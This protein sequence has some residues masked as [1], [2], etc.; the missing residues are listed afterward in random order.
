MKI[1]K[2]D[3]K[4]TEIP[5]VFESSKSLSVAYLKLVFK[6]S[7]V[8]RENK[9]GLAKLSAMLLNEGDM[10]L[11]SHT[12]AK[13]LEKR[14]ISLHANAGFE[15]FNF[16]INCLKEHF[17][18]GLSMLKKLLKSPNLTSETLAKCKS[19]TLGE[20][21]NNQN[22]N[23]YLAQVGLNEILYAN[24]NLGYAS[25]GDKKSIDDISLD[26]VRDF[27]KF[28]DLSNLFI[29][30]GGDVNESELQNI[31]DVLNELEVGKKAEQITLKTSNNCELKEIIKKSEQAYVYFGA[32]YHVSE[33]ERYMASVAMYILG[34]G[35]F[36][37][38]LM[39]EVRVKRGLAYS[40]YAR[41]LYNLSHSHVYG[42]LQTKNESKDEAISVVKAEFDKFYKHGVSK[43]ELDLAKKFLQGSLALRLETLFR[44]LNIAESEFYRGKELGSFLHEL[45]KIKA[46]KLDKLNEFIYKH[47]EI[48]QLSF[49]VLRDEI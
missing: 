12:F 7:G 11:G 18:F 42:Y 34:E 26:D 45:N 16:E 39:E 29:V 5:V 20:I 17:D 33:D 9:K 1:K 10:S 21:A 3:V 44:R 32:P 30:Y 46:L 22:D 36:G 41:G 31:K 38:R 37:A 23:D 4:N 19:L 15:T 25:I 14:A 13:E 28:L 35:G 27:I 47:N 49:C 24:T 40:A 48:S 2:I 43:K 8:I 6:N